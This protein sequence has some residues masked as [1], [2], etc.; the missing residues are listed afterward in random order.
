MSFTP[1]ASTEFG[2]PA[3]ASATSSVR[4]ARRAAL[5][6][7]LSALAA[8]A[9]PAR[10]Q[11][12]PERPVRFIVPF[13]PGGPVDTVARIVGQKL[14]EQWGQPVLVENRAGAGGIVGAEAALR[15]G[16][17]GYAVFVC[18]IHHTVLP[19]LYP[20]LSYDIERDFEPVAF[21]ARFPI[22]LAAHPSVPAQSVRELIAL[23]KQQP[24]KL[25]YGSS[26]NGGGTHLAGELFNVQA[27]TQMLHVPYRGSAPAVADLLG[28]TVQLMFADA[29]S[30]MPHLRS[31]R[32]RALGVANAER[33]EMLPGVPTVSESGLPGYAAYSWTGFVVP[34]G[35]PK[36]ASARLAQEIA[37]VVANAD[38]QRRMLDAGAEARPM[39]PAEFGAF[40]RAELAQWS[41]VVK[42]ADIRPD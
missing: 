20:K 21:G 14:A 32:L 1:F 26:G 40:M 41:R 4:R 30:V 42:A 12:Y 38:I 13:P 39:G 25:S 34:A 17:D 6:S 18:S 15:A 27:G 24:G 11:A 36:P 2:W 7:A 22:V 37:R 35:T 31:G 28:G 33:T 10:A 29:V 19:S 9:L 8:T 5:T 23:A 3:S 16:N